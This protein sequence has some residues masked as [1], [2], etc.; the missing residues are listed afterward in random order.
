MTAD[1]PAAPSPSSPGRTSRRRALGLLGAGGAAL[2]ASLLGRDEA[3]AGHDGTNVMHLGQVNQ[4]PGGKTTLRASFG[5]GEG[6][7]LGDD[8]LAVSG[9]VPRDVLYVAAEG[10]GSALHVDGGTILDWGANPK[11]RRARCRQPPPRGR[12]RPCKR[13]HGRQR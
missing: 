10:G 2:F 3:R 8:V 7:L 9:D 1:A 11:I 13:L 6:G 5:S 12:R 4:S